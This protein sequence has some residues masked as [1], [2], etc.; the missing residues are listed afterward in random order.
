VLLPAPCYVGFPSDLSLLGELTP[1][2]VRISGAVDQFTDVGDAMQCYEDTRQKAEKEGMKVK[3]LVLCNPHN[4]LGRCYTRGM[5]VGVMQFCKRW[6]IH[7]VVD[8]V[9]AM[10]VYNPT[11]T[12][13]TS[14]LALDPAPHIE[15]NFLHHIYG[16]SKDFASGGLR[17]ASL[18]TYNAA[19]QRAV[20]KLA[21]LHHSGTIPS[22]LATSILSSPTFHET[23]FNASRTRLAAGATLAKSLLDAQGIRYAPGSNAGFFL[24]VDLRPWLKGQDGDDEW[25]LEKRLSARMQV[26]KVFMVGGRVQGAVEAGW[27]RFIFSRKEEVVREG[28][29]RLVRALRKKG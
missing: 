13:F 17:I 2:Y 4:P 7:L 22:L 20:S 15:K 5:L 28:L 26:E 21:I 1:V 11:D 25:E 24:W 19:L 29:R 12:P 3:M 27:Y 16:L 14:I 23:F 8:E 18:H 10:S 6:G 9:Y